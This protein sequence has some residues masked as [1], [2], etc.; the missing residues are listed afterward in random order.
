MS[1]SQLARS[2][3][4]GLCD[5]LVKAGSDAPTLCEGWQTRDLA[6]HLFVRERRPLAM[7]GNLLGGR[8]AKLTGESM[9]EALRRYGYIGL[10]AKVRSGPPALLRPVDGLVNLVEFFVHTEDVRRAAPNW[11]PRDNP[12]LDA[13]LWASLGLMSRMTTRKLQGAG[14]ELERPDGERIVARRAQPRAVLSGGAQE[15]VL[16]LSGRSQVANVSLNGPEEATQAVRR[17]HF[18]L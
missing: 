13:A 18:A 17:T 2:E 7:T 1:A 9:A 12:Q 16:Y 8:F 14:L 4:S 5:A 15:L 6:A 11:A 3:R 10:V